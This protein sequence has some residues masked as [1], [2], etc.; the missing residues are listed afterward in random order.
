MAN[1]S[2]FGYRGSDFDLTLAT[3]GFTTL[4]AGIVFG[5]AHIAH[6]AVFGISH[7][8]LI[9]FVGAGFFAAAAWASAALVTA[10]IAQAAGFGAGSADN[11]L[12]FA[13]GRFAAFRADIIFV[14]TNI[15]GYSGTIRTN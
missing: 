5:L 12:V 3:R 1:T 8:A 2:G 15:F 13:A 10:D 6:G 9:F 11:S 4:G 14:S 7:T